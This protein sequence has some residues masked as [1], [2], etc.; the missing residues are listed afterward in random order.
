M[1]E[2]REISTHQEGRDAADAVNGAL[3]FDHGDGFCWDFVGQ[4]IRV[5]IYL[6]YISKHFGV[7]TVDGSEILL[8]SWGW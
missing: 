8:A 3:V 5:G 4:L 1:G 7:D 6:G 2:V